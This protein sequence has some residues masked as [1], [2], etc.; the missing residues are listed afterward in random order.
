MSTVATPAP[1]AQ[2]PINHFGRIIGAIV[3]P[4]KTFAE[5]VQRPSWI[6]P[7]LV[8]TV[9]SAAVCFGINQRIDWREYIGHQME[10]SPS[11]AQLTPEQKQQR[12]EGGAKFAPIITYVFGIPALLVI[13]LIVAAVMLGA[14]NLLG[15]ASLNFRTSMGI[16][17]HAFSPGVISSVLFLLVLYLKPF[18]TVDLDNPVATNVGALLGEDAPKWLHKLGASLDVFSFWSLFLIAIGFAA[19]SP[20]KLTFGKSFG[21]AVAVWAVYV[22]AKVGWASIFS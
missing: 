13:T 7:V 12:V 4:K 11:T 16:V 20:K 10:Q 15:G 22:V 19:A 3:S 5:I 2:P 14:Y 17:S 8:L 18:G 9:L 6:A 1:E 21:I